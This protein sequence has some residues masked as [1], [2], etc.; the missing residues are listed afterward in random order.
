M[1]T[2]ITDVNTICRITVIFESRTIHHHFLVINLL[3]VI[4]ITHT[5]NDKLM[6]K[7]YIKYLVATFDNDQNY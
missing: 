2:Y 7:S 5:L 6:F 4:E 1:Y 3:L